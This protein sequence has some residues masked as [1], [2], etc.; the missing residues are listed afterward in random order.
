[1]ETR[2]V[3]DIHKSRNIQICHYK[4]LGYRVN[5]TNASDCPFSDDC[6][7]LVAKFNEFNGELGFILLK[8]DRTRILKKTN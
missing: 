6:L 7:A 1:M 2:P 4:Y 5:I 8:K 3:K